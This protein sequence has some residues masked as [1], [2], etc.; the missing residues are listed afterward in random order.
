MRAWRLAA[1][2][3]IVFVTLFLAGVLAPGPGP[4]DINDSNDAVFVFFQQHHH[5]LL[6]SVILL[7]LAFVAFLW[8]LGNLVAELRRG[9]EP[10]L[11]AVAF[12]GGVAAS[13]IAYLAIAIRATITFRTTAHSP[14]TE[15]D[16][17]YDFEF[18]TATIINFPLAVLVGA[19]SLAAWRSSVLPR[20]FGA[21]GL[22]G[23]PIILA[24]GGAID[25][26]G[27]YAPD[28]A[29]AIVALIV[30]LA[31]TLAASTLLI[32]RP[33]LEEADPAVS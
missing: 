12:G 31:W 10:R 30:F 16:L 23:A 6:A 21:A 9:G 33:A 2:T 11:A 7:G 25:Q 22:I 26:Q 32:T 24:A 15:V 14:V 28:G 3:G 13:A 27:F 4:P 20:R 18:I 19:V 1:T 8:F 17:M 29:Y 5:A